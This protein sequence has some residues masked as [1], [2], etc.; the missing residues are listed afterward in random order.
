[1]IEVGGADVVDPPVTTDDDDDGVVA[2]FG[3]FVVM[4]VGTKGSASTSKPNS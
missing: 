2:K 1:M 3:I 4:V